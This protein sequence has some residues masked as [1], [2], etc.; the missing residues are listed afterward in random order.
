MIT[1]GRIVSAAEAQARVEGTLDVD[2]EAWVEQGMS[3]V[4]MGHIQMFVVFPD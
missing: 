4:D 2:A 3:D 1:E